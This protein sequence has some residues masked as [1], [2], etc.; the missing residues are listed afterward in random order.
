MVR[1]IR[2]WYEMGDPGRRAADA[3][4]GV[5]VGVLQANELRRQL[6]ERHVPFLTGTEGR[7]L[8][9]IEEGYTNEE[10]A[11]L[12]DVAPATVRRH[13]AD[14]CHKVFDLTEIPPQREKLRSWIPLHYACCTLGVQKLIENDQKM[15]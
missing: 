8:A 11:E 5:E 6:R 13:V 9:F 7:I 4:P 15:C 3:I 12:M 1:P 14:L 10:A 2:M